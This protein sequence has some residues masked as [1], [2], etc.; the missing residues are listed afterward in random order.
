ML[1]NKPYF[2]SPLLLGLI[3]ILSMAN[4]QS[5]EMKV[6]RQTAQTLTLLLKKN[7]IE[8]EQKRLPVVGAF[9][10]YPCSLK[11]G[12]SLFTFAWKRAS[13]FFRFPI[14]AGPLLPFYLSFFSFYGI[15]P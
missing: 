8:A 5:R 3:A 2:W 6:D 15:L 10:F 4:G 11:G 13:Y 12:I 1:K 7:D 9:L 14:R